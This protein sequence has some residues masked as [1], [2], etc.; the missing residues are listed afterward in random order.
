MRALVRALPIVV[1]SVL[2]SPGGPA[3]VAGHGGHPTCSAGASTPW[4]QRINGVDHVRG[5]HDISCTGKVG[6]IE[7]WGRLLMDGRV[8][9]ERSRVCDGP[10]AA[11]GVV[12][13]HWNP[14]GKQRWQA[15]TG[16]RFRWAGE[17]HHV[18][19]VTSPAA[20]H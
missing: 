4:V 2:L 14:S 19:S 10:V 18:A 6:K 16:G 13:L 5:T 17:W 7:V 8:V 1:V 11:C 9:D 3:A 20:Y 15:R 12:T